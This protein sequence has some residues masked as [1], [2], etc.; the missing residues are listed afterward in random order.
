MNEYMKQKLIEGLNISEQEA[1]NKSE[2]DFT[3]MMAIKNLEIARQ[4]KV[5]EIEIKKNANN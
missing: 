2:Y 3:L 1:W 5:Q 4:N